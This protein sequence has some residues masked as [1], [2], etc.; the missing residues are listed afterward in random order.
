MKQD[1]RIRFRELGMTIGRLKT[2][3]HNAITDVKGILVGHS[4]IIEGSGKLI[5]GKGPVRTGIT[6]IHPS[7]GDV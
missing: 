6:A 3:E 2:G 4:T 1:K 7:S 5:R